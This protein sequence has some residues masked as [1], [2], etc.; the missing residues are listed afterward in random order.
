MPVRYTEVLLIL[1]LLRG[2]QIRM[3]YGCTII[4]YLLQ[5]MLPIIENKQI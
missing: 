3:W 2:D 5:A 1:I 4:N